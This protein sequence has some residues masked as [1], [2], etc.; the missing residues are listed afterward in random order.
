MPW[1]YRVCREILPNGEEDLSIRECWVRKGA[2]LPYSVDTPRTEVTGIP[3]SA[4]QLTR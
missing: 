4:R 3:D 2:R 1:T